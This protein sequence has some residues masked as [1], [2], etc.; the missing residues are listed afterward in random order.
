MA[1]ICKTPDHCSVFS[2]KLSP[3]SSVTKSLFIFATKSSVLDNF[4]LTLLFECLLGVLGSYSTFRKILKMT[5]N[6]NFVLVALLVVKLGRKCLLHLLFTTIYQKL[7][8]IMLQ[9]PLVFL[10]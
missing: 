10:S 4:K 2:S 9:T 1:G 5:C 3:E 7:Q 6:M 8:L